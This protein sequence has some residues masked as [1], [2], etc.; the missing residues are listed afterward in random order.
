MKRKDKKI[1]IGRKGKERWYPKYVPHIILGTNI[2]I[3][4]T[5]TNNNE[6]K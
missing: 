6:T 4:D 3:F 1:L 5:K 2:S